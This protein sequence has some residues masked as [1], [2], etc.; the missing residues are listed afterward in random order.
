MTPIVQFALHKWIKP[1]KI[2]RIVEHAI[3]I[4]ILNA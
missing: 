1:P 3:N 2:Y 4:F